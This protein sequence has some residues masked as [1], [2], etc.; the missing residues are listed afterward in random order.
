MLVGEMDVKEE[1]WWYLSDLLSSINTMKLPIPTAARVIRPP[2]LPERILS[3]RTEMDPN[4][5]L[6]HVYFSE[7]SN[8]NGQAL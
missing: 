4:S 5:P 3:F 2:V 8:V 7:L 1:D 6:M